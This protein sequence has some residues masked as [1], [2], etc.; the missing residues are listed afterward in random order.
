MSC[1]SA[2]TLNRNRA[3]IAI[4]PFVESKHLY[5]SS[6]SPP[7]SHSPTHPLI[8]I[9]S[10]RLHK[11]IYTKP[12][13]TE[14]ISTRWYRAP[15]CL[16]TNGFYD[17][18]MD[19][20]GIGCVFFEVVSLFPLFPGTNELDQIQK[21]HSILGTPSPKILASFK[22]HSSHI[23]NFNFPYKE[24]RWEGRCTCPRAYVS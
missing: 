5:A 3:Y 23:S 2:L 8:P 15:E 4:Y 21:V 24:G 14:Y 18:K 13:Y 22:K 9:P 20:W 1:T 6:S 16:L 11:G 12:P 10:I 7:T 19:I 17:S